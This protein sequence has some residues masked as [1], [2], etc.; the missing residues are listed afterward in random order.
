MMKRNVSDIHLIRTGPRSNPP[1]ILVHPVG[2]DLTYW[3]AQIDALRGAFDV[4]AYDLPGNG[5]T[6]GT[7]QD[8]SIDAAA[9]VLAQVAADSESERVSVVGIS[10]GGMIAQAFALAHPEALQSMVLIGTAASFSEEQRGFARNRAAV[11]RRDGLSS[12]I[13]PTLERWFTAETRMRRPDIID[14]VT[15]SLSADDPLIYAAMWE[16]IAQLHLAPRLGEIM[17]PTLIM[18]GDRD[19]ICPPDVARALHAGI[20]YAQLTIVPGAAHMCILEQPGFINERLVA[21][22]ESAGRS[23]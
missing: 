2:L 22:L 8:W 5:S 13:P 21:F 9:E 6:P 15:K 16:M 18:T 7:A 23:S 3:G 1:V 17:C 14:R 19:P 4:I 10:I 20:P 12:I 11:A